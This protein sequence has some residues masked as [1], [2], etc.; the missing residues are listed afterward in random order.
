MRSAL[1]LQNVPTNIVSNRPELNSLY[2]LY[3]FSLFF[4]FDYYFSVYNF[5]LTHTDSSQSHVT[6][7]RDPADWHVKEPK[8]KR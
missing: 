6:G 5:A 8:L 3:K 2:P 7:D 4:F 1:P